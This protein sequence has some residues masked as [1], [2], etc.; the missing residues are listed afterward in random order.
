[1][2]FINFQNVAH[3]KTQIIK[4]RTVESIHRKLLIT[5]I[6]DANTEKIY[7]ESLIYE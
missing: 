1:M 3:K 2:W 7:A 5:N 6:N 4:M